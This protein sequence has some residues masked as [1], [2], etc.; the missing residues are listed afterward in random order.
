MLSIVVKMLG[1]EVTVAHDGLDSAGHGAKVSPGAW[2]SSISACLEW[3][4]MRLPCEFEK[5]HGE[6]K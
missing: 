2:F 4:A 6:K 1:N 5:L 3:M